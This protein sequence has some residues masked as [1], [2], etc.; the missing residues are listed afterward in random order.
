MRS[1]SFYIDSQINY[2]IDISVGPFNVK[3]FLFYNWI[4]FYNIYTV[5]CH[6][7][8]VV[9]SP[10][11]WVVAL[12]EWCVHHSLN[13]WCI[14]F[15]RALQ[16]VVHICL[17]LQSL[18]KELVQCPWYLWHRSLDLLLVQVR[19]WNICFNISV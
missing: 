16:F 17:Q 15:Q 13:R 8:C 1:A 7:F 6:I 11:L 19:S 2:G 18:R 12:S 10:Y 14:S 3:I 5:L 4:V 9:F